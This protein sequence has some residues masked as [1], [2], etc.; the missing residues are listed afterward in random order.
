MTFAPEDL[1]QLLTIATAKVDT[2]VA[3]AERIC[4]VPAPTGQ[5]GPRAAFVATLFRERGYTPEIDEMGNVY[6]IRCGQQHMDTPQHHP[7][8][9]ML[10]AHLDTVFPL[11]TPITIQH[12]GDILH[13]PGIGDNS[14]SVAALLTLLE[15]L[16][17]LHIQTEND[18]I[19]V[20]NVGE[21]GLGNLRGARQA[22]ERYRSQLGMVIVVDGHL[23]YIVNRAVGSL[24]WRVIVRGPGGH[25][26]G[27]FGTPSAIHGL[28]RIIAAIA[29]LDVPREPGV[30]TTYNVGVIEGGTSVNTIA[31]SASALLDLRSTSIASL[32]ALADRVRTI[33]QQVANPGLSTEIEVLGERPAGQCALDDPLVEIAK[34]TLAWLGINARCV[35]SSTDANIPMSLGI[36]SICVG[37]T[38]VEKAHTLQEHI[39]ISPVKKGLAQLLRLTIEASSLLA[40][41]S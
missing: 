13:G 21:E 38:H 14:I 37:I 23:G 10:L 24:R 17:E 4:A 12:D 1:E 6:A 32:H 39:Y 35:A 30:R 11:D 27:S 25:S 26:F 3:L 28:G 7:P 15:I 19:A 34:E 9:L 18:L 36:P 5:E 40:A 20:A 8:A 22:V 41:M 16:D 2:V 31:S 33:I 29:D